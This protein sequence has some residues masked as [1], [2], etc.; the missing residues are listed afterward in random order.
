MCGIT[1][2]VGRGDAKVLAS[3]NNALRHRGPDD[4]GQ[5]IFPRKDRGTGTVGLAQRRLSI[6][7]L[8]PAGHQPLSNENGNVWVSFNGEIYNHATLR[9]GLTQEHRFRGK[10]DTEVIVHLYEELGE[11]VFEKLE[12]MFA[13]ALYDK[14]RD[15]L[16]LAR[17]RMGKKPLY[18]AVMDG[19]LMFGS[20]LKA[21]MHH[22]SFRKEIDPSALNAYF[23]YEH[24]PT[25]QSIFKDTHKL[26]PGTYLMW[27]GQAATKT[28]FW[29]PTFLPKH[30]SFTESLRLLDEAF[31][32]S[33]RDRLVADVPLGIFLS[34]GIDSSTVAYYAAKESSRKV[35]TYA[36]GFEEASFDESAYARR[37]AEHLGTEHHERRLTAQDSLDL[38]P[39]IGDL[40]D[41]P[42]ADSSIL[43]TYLLS[44]F[45]REHVTVALGGD[46]GDELFAGYDTF[47][48]YRFTALYERVPKPL[49]SLVRTLV[50]QLPTS[51]RHMSLDFRLKRFTQGFE[52]NPAYRNQRWIAA[53]DR[54]E[55]EQL[56]LPEVWNE[57]S[58]T[59]EFAN[60]ARYLGEM[61]SH[62]R[63]DELAYLFQRTYMMDQVLVK[64]DRASMAHALEVRAPFLDTRVVDLAN[65]LPPSFKLRGLTRKYILKKLME[66]KLP[67]DILYR[68]KQGFGTPIGSWLKGPLAPWMQEVLAPAELTKT[69]LFNPTYVERLVA[70]HLDGRRDNRKQLWTLLVFMLWYRRW[71]VG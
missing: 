11:R 9:R 23:L 5:E 56:L 41:E 3:M 2:Y 40:L 62:D 54:S 22:P 18:Y 21:L 12:G 24:V 16:F 14:A 55:R 7:D 69:G 57:V 39:E 38:I 42:M 1:G 44:K 67:D 60:L 64:V 45:T 31:E 20:E 49:R 51:H 8:S 63:Y 6:I 33:V 68:K 10:S 32:A 61:D 27:D 46:G 58:N 15:L 26:E 4:G 29:K 37:V 30:A 52:G 25:P 66:G 71:M 19:T 28:Q 48:A 35:K 34:G 36:I 50:H 17:D 13:I 65:H 53:F 43:P 59:D 70:E 47:L